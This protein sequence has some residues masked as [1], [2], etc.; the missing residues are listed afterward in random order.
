MIKCYHVP[1]TE[2]QL[3]LL[4]IAV[5]NERIKHTVSASKE[6]RLFELEKA[7]DGAVEV[8]IWKCQK[9]DCACSHPLTFHKADT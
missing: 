8:G 5:R 9:A 2:G 1:V 7:L 4:R 6:R 3:M